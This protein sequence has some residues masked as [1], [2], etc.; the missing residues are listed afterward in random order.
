MKILLLF[1]NHR[2]ELYDN[3]IKLQRTYMHLHKNI[4]SYIVEMKE[5]IDKEILIENDVIYVKGKENI[6]NI[7]HKTLTSIR[8][9]LK[10]YNFDYIVRTNASTVTDLEKLYEYCK[11]SQNTNLYTGGRILELEWTDYDYGIKDDTYFG[12]TFIQGCFIVF[13]IDV[14]HKILDNIKDLHLD[15]VDDVSFAIYI[16]EHTHITVSDIYKKKPLFCNDNLGMTKLADYSKREYV[17]YRNHRNISYAWGNREADIEEI[18]NQ[19]K[20][21]NSHLIKNKFTTD[22][23]Q[24]LV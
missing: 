9:L 2:N 14:I 8:F 24:T 19:I 23:Y 6:K 15:I 5:D 13:S 18:K 10:Y 12:L 16:K 3:M 4:T 11:K 20:Y 21:V 17:A 7:L 1:I 22:Y